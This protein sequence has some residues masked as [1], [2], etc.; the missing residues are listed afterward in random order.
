[1]RQSQIANAK[2]I[3]VS[4]Q[5]LYV[6]IQRDYVYFL[7]TVINHFMKLFYVAQFGVSFTNYFV[8]T[9]TFASYLV[10]TSLYA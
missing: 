5:L 3:S 4:M 2:T 8:F 1:M 9:L 10:F 7:V 6:V